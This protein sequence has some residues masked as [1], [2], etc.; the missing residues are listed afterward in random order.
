VRIDGR[1]V[2]DLPPNRRD[3]GIVFQNY[4][5][6]P[7]MSVAENVA[8]G[9]RARGRRG[10]KVRHR[11]AE[12]LDLVQLGG[13]RDRRPAQL[14]GVNSSASHLPVR[15]RLS[16]ASCCSMSP[17]PRSTAASASTCRSRSSGCN[18]VSD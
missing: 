14:S 8:Y 1:S 6:F 18:G 7:H 3:V 9:L 16:R 10:E 13:L 4:A 15:S 12:L 2:D 11:V 5:L 17:L